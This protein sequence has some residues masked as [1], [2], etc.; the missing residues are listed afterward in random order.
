MVRLFLL[1]FLAGLS[2]LDTTQ[3]MERPRPLIV[4]S[5][6]PIH[7]WTANIAGTNAEVENLLPPRAEPH[8][9]AFTPGDARKLS[10]ANLILVNGLNLESWLPKLLRSAP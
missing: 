9:Y 2:V 4:T 7:C 10:Q 8:E 6:F 5:F 3:A 1:T